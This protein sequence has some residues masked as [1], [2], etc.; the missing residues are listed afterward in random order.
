MSGYK[1]SKVFRATNNVTVLST[2]TLYFIMFLC[3]LNM[4][5]RTHKK[6]FGETY[7]VKQI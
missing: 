1:P 4:Y 3:K 2:K 6:Y 5:E 7:T